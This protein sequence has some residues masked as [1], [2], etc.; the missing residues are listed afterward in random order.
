MYHDNED[1][2][3]FIPTAEVPLTSLYRDE[4]L[5]GA[6]ADLYDRVHALF[7]ARENVCRA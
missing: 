4:I 3:W 5:D 6:S 7:S 2:Y 1:D